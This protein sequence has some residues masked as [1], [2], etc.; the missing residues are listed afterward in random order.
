MSRLMVKLLQSD[1]FFEEKTL[2]NLLNVVSS[3]NFV[4]KE[5]GKE[6][7]N[8]QLIQPGIDDVLSRVV[9][10]SLIVDQEYSGIFRIP[11][12]GIHFESFQSPDEWRFSIALEKTTFNIYYHL[13][14]AKNALEGYKFNY[15][16]LF[17]W[18]YHTNVLLEPNQGIFYRPWIFHSFSGGILQNYRLL[19]TQSNIDKKIILVMGLP[20]TGKTRLIEK[21]SE[22]LDCCVLNSGNIRRMYN[23]NDFTIEG[24][25]N[26]AMKLRN[27]VHF[28]N[29][30]YT[31][32][33]SVCPLIMTRDYVS[34]DFIIW[35]NTQTNSKYND[36]DKMFE[37]PS[38]SNLIINDFNYNIETILEQIK[39]EIP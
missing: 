5:Y 3:F 4:E 29:K 10:E 38:N 31:I 22:K 34:P 1:N 23:D 24:R 30:K 14:G 17:E 25:T 37:K 35:M 33:E 20:G 26:H 13:S 12:M 15:N 2:K 11:N 16:N 27:L 7:E 32:I 18:D 21:L 36:T 39:N 9:G 28:S 6:I 19:S 8:F